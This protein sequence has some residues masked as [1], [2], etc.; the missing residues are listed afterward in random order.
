MRLTLRRLLLPMALLPAMLGASG[1]SYGLPGDTVALGRVQLH[2][3][4]NR[5]VPYMPLA[6]QGASA[7]TAA[8]S[9]QVIRS[10]SLDGDPLQNVYANLR[11]IDVDGDGRFEFVQW[12]GFRFM[13]VWSADGRKLW[14]IEDP[15]GRLND[16]RQG[17]LRD[18]AAVLDLDGDGKQDIAHCW[19]QGGQRR[20]VYRRGLDGRVITSVPID[21]GLSRLCQIAAFDTAERGTLILVAQSNRIASACAHNYTDSW[22]RTVAYDVAQRVVW[23]RATCDAGHFVYPLDENGDGKVEGIQVGKYLLRPDGSLRCQL[24]PWVP[25]DHVDTL[26]TADLDPARP[27]LETVAVGLTGAAMFSASDC[28]QIWRLPGNVVVNPQHVT[29]AKLDPASA[30][31]LI[32][33]HEKASTVRPTMFFVNGQGRILHRLD[34]GIMPMQ[35]ANLDGALGT[36]ELVASFGVV[37][38]QLGR[39][40]LS[41]SWYWRL[42]GDRVHETNQGPFPASFDRWQAFPL[43][44]DVDGDGRDEIVQWS[45]SLVVIGKVR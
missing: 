37:L 2:R 23:D 29:V 45:Q 42:K 4:Y 26:A 10:F 14:R 43:V 20:L 16:E 5:G 40:R 15:A 39:T 38:D 12:N 17:V 41:E 27:G 6:Q 32:V 44:F 9:V 35:N 22:A 8:L 28:H 1:T 18:T 13:Q 7:G 19:V 21:G 34:T 24:T 33:I 3:S 31:P 30:T 36:D 25:G 11:P